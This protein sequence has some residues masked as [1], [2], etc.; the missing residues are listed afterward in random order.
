AASPSTS[1]ASSAAYSITVTDSGESSASAGTPTQTLS[2]SGGS[3]I[4]VSW[5]ADDPDNDRLVYTLAFRG[6]DETQWK[7]LR[8]NLFENSLLLDGDILADGRYY[9]RVTASDRPSNAQSDARQAELIS[10][11]VLID[12]TPPVVKFQEPVRSSD[13]HFEVLVDAQDQ[14]SPLRRCEYSVDAASWLPVEAA[15]GVTDSPQEQFR[16]VLDRV[17]AGEHLLVVRVFDAAGN[18]GLA[19]LVLK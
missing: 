15:D 8:T 14:T 17:R 9:F 10:S 3:Q 2:R 7:L 5:Q 13:G 6:E 4:Q 18:A 12:N 1:S 19:K 11:P 16:I